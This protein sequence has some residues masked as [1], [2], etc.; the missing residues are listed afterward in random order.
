MNRKSA[1]LH[2]HAIMHGVNFLVC[3]YEKLCA[4]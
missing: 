1:R 4:P 3:A 2:V